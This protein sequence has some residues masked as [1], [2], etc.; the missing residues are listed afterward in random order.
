MCSG[1]VTDHQHPSTAQYHRSWPG[2]FP[3]S[4]SPR[5][6]Q[7]THAI[8]TLP[9]RRAWPFPHSFGTQSGQKSGRRSIAKE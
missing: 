1:S 6:V 4:P 5:Q 3:T 9:G 8:R 7:V 2:G